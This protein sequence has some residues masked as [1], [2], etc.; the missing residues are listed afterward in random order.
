MKTQGMKTQGMKTQGMKTQGGAAPVR[1]AIRV[2]P[3][4]SRSSVGG[5]YGAGEDARLTVAVS[6]RAV[7]GAATEAVLVAIAKAL[8]VRRRQVLLVTGRTS[9]DKV[10][11]VT[12]DDPA[13][14]RVLIAQLLV[15]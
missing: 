1:V 11:E 14:V 8:G 9:R 4:A 10:I 3:G 12:T 2:R 13:R 6:A 15:G 5:S 7:D